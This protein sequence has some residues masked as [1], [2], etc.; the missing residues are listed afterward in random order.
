M[1]KR[2][3][4]NIKN[5]T[6]ESCKA[7][8]NKRTWRT[9]E[10]EVDPLRASLPFRKRSRNALHD[11]SDVPRAAP[12]ASK[13]TRRPF[14]GIGKPQTA[15][16]KRSRTWRRYKSGS[17]DA[18]YL[19]YEFSQKVTDNESSAISSFFAPSQI[20]QTEKVE[21]GLLIKKRWVGLLI[22][23]KGGSI[24]EILKKSNAN[25]DFGDEDVILR[26]N[27]GSE[28]WEEE[29][30]PTFEN[31]KYAVC[32][33]SGTKAQATDAAKNVAVFTGEAAQSPNYKLEFLIPDR[34]C[35]IFVGKKGANMR[36]MKGPEKWNVSVKLR[37][38]SISLGVTKV[39]VCTIFGPAKNALKAI[40][41][42]SNWLGA[43]SVKIQMDRDAARQK[44]SLP[45]EL[46]PALHPPNADERS[47]I[48][49]GSPLSYRDDDR[50][51]AV[52]EYRN[53][54]PRSHVMDAMNPTNQSGDLFFY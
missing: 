40:E 21:L 22:G 48:G 36:K 15:T 41:R 43:I 12:S 4:R 2:W 46:P 14:G 32:A 54:P 13:L 23:K 16:N 1:V 26:I 47:R 37:D 17:R 30:W 27:P 8:G 25:I 9:R 11:L 44:E 29:P 7:S 45:R 19:S 42:A 10:D 6:P 39:S 20:D 34:Y 51:F 28:R 53:F 33:I 18:G 31:E 5:N 3:G 24:R 52:D 50:D 38:C 35:G 49:G